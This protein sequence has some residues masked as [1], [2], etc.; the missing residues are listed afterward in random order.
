MAPR[1]RSWRVQQLDRRGAA[2]TLVTLPVEMLQ[3]IVEACDEDSLR[4]AYCVC[5]QLCPLVASELR[6]RCLIALVGTIPATV[7]LEQVVV[8][9][10][11]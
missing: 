8:A 1:T 6:K 4:N 2:D 10:R 11:T 9:C 5:K 7:T 3:L